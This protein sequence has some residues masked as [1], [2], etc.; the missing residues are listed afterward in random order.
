MAHL[1]PVL[2]LGELGDS[3]VRD[4][5]PARPSIFLPQNYLTKVCWGGSYT[6][7]KEDGKPNNSGD[8]R[9]PQPSN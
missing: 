5:G 8:L 9:D 7:L 6:Q 3:G 1:L 2:D 4:F